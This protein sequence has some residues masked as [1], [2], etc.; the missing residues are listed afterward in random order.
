MSM[1][2]NVCQN[3][4][5]QSVFVSSSNRSVT[6]LNKVI[7]GTTSVY[8]CERCG[9]TQTNE[10]MDL[11]RYYALEYEINMAS[12]EDDQIYQVIDGKTIY[13]SHHQADTLMAK[14][15]FQPGMKLLDYGC[16][17]GATL[18]KVMEK[19]S[20]LEALFFDVTDKYIESWSKIA[21]KVQWATH[22]PDPKWED[23]VDVLTSF[24][25]LEHVSDLQ[26][27]VMN[28]KRLLKDGGL[29][30]CIVPNMYENIADFIVADHVNHFSEASLH[31]L[32]EQAGFDNISVDTESHHSAFVVTA[33]NKKY[34]TA[35]V[36]VV[37]KD[38]FDLKEQ[39]LEMAAFWKKL[40]TRLSEF[41]A[42]ISDLDS[43]AIYG[44][45]FYGFY[46]SSATGK[47]KQLSCFIDQNSHLQGREMG[48]KPILS[49]EQ[50]PEQVNYVLVGL[51]P[52]YAKE[53]IEN[54]SHWKS[55][56]IQ[57]F[58]L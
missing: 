48:G 55:R 17:K 22:E 37:N 5:M 20:E 1:K 16:A 49:I 54:I 45:G 4:Q 25:A 26:D 27:A 34:V 57:Y 58:Y 8:F 31:Y 44:A 3:D 19:H 23:Q 35:P 42:Q 29:F 14:V 7:E 53:V 52:R 6:T 2:C 33:E 39:C 38:T 40:Q 13:R 41:E 56:E 46:L 10:I 43:L 12:D 28:V 24:Y 32:L 9:H 15:D 36:N 18:K 11:A 21:G 51:N 30:Y 47:T 50:L